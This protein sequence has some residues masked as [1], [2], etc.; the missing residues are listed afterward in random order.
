MTLERPGI[1]H[2]RSVRRGKGS[3][4]GDGLEHL[5]VIS[6]GWGGGVNFAGKLR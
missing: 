1:G 5:V 4:S 3:A 2:E 6:L